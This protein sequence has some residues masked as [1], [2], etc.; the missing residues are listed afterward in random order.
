MRDARTKSWSLVRL[1]SLFAFYR[2]RMQ[3]R[4]ARVVGFWLVSFDAFSYI[5]RTNY[6]SLEATKNECLLRVETYFDPFP[7]HL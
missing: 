3:A 2:D 6:P 5:A 1:L 4:V 7:T